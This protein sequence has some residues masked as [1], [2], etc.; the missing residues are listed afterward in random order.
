MAL[1]SVTSGPIDGA[2]GKARPEVAFP[3]APPEGLVPVTPPVGEEAFP[4]VLEVPVRAPLPVVH[5]GALGFRPG[6]SATRSRRRMR[7]RESAPELGGCFPRFCK[8][9]RLA[10]T[11]DRPGERR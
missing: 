3:D 1:R 6:G 7:L 8:R 9:R 11:R 2:I 10:R 4:T 5:F